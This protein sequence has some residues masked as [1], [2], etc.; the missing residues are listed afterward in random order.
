MPRK[1]RGTVQPAVV[2]QPVTPDPNE[3]VGALDAAITAA[4]SA[5]A[6]AGVPKGFIVAVLHA[7]ALK[8]TQL[9]LG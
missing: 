7:H 2:D 9:L 3:G 5:A 6:E 8:Q 1:P 4:L